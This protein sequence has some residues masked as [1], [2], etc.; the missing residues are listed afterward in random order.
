M[1]LIVLKFVFIISSFNYVLAQDTITIYYN[2]NWTKI[3]DKNQA[4]YYRKAYIDSNKVWTAHDYY[5]SN[6][7]Q[8]I[9]TFKSKRLNIKQGHFIYFYEN[10]RKSSEGECVNDKNEGFWTDW[11]EN[12]QKKSEGKFKNDLRQ[13]KWTYWHENGHIKSEGLYINDNAEDRWEYWFDSGE[14][15]SEGKFLHGRKDGT[16]K[17]FYKT[18]Q[19]ETVEEYKDCRLNFIMSYFENGNIKFKGNCVNGQSDGEWTYWNVDGRLI[20]KGNFSNNLQVGEWTRL[21]PNGE[22]MKIYY[23]K[24][25]LVSKQLGGISK[26]E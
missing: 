19:I 8:M 22:S 21:F 5:V 12:G 1:R 23:E 3:S 4:T 11:H 10:G 6:R 24:G 7:I 18:G 26:N 15:Q 16:W 9:G 14:K 25:I 2:N 17:Y 13:N 20:L